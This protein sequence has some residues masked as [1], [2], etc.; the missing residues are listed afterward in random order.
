MTVESGA[1]EVR[2]REQPRGI[3]LVSYASASIDC[4]C[5]FERGR[6]CTQ[7]SMNLLEI[8]IRKI[9]AI[10]LL[11]CSHQ[12]EPKWISEGSTQTVERSDTILYI[13]GFRIC[14]LWE[15]LEFDMRSTHVYFQTSSKISPGPAKMQNHRELVSIFVQVDIL[16]T[17]RARQ[18]DT[19]DYS[20]LECATFVVIFLTM[21]VERRRDPQETYF[22]ESWNGV[23]QSRVFTDNH[24][25]D[26]CFRS[27]KRNTYTS[28]KSLREFFNRLDH[29]TRK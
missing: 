26:A 4:T 9:W 22:F 13:T 3:Y 17:F 6:V 23:H 19:I 15:P 1:R 20:H 28:L 2:E 27:K 14:S 8:R 12:V 29:A 16:P 7:F 11:R 24:E 21:S 18:K 5:L 10:H 25:L